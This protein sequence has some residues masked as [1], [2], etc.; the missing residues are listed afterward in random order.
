M[1]QAVE[2]PHGW[3]RGGFVVAKLFLLLIGVG[4]L[5][6]G[7]RRRMRI[8]LFQK[9]L[10]LLKIVERRFQTGRICPGGHKISFRQLRFWAVS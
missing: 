1:V 7:A 10:P 2:F 8:A 6:R 9:V 4:G 5:E 3:A